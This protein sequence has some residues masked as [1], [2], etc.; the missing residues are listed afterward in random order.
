MLL[1][2][3]VESTFPEEQF[4]PPPGSRAPPWFGPSSGS[5]PHLN[6]P[7]L[8]HNGG[9]PACPTHGPRGPPHPGV[10][11]PP[12]PP[13]AN[14]C[15][16]GQNSKYSGFSP[17]RVIWSWLWGKLAL[18]I[19]YWIQWRGIREYAAVE[20]WLKMDSA[21]QSEAQ[22]ERREVKVKE[23]QR[24]VAFIF[25]K[26]S[27]ACGE[28]A[29]AAWQYHFKA[30]LRIR[31]NYV[32]NENWWRNCFQFAFLNSWIGRRDVWNFKFWQS[33]LSPVWLTVN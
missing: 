29:T 12:P 11:P 28:S 15:L 30:F 19:T 24:Y 32:D 10:G 25:C 22:V 3:Q 6:R 17:E 21:R 8:V 33:L 2:F 1:H 16:P 27:N 7:C 23:Q 9:P 20:I 14:G 13:N 31:E 26:Y 4:S 5:L 18:L